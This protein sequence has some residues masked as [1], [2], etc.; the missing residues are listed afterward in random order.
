MAGGKGTRL[1]PLTDPL[2]KHTLP[3]YNEP[4]IYKVVR[5]LVE[6]GVTDI[7]VSLNHIHAE[8]ILE[9]LEDGE[10]FGCALY[11][12]YQRDVVSPGKHLCAAERWVDGDDFILMLG[13]SLYLC[14]LDLRTPKAP[15]I[16]AMPL[17]GADDPRKYGQVKLAD[18]GRV[19]KLVEKPSELF[20]EIIQTAVWKFPPDIFERAKRMRR[21]VAGETHIGMLSTEYVDEGLMTYS[22]IPEG[23]YLDLGTP[24]ALLEGWLRV[25]RSLKQ[26]S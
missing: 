14:P 9:M 7:L 20:S 25:A 6:G 19:L 11:Y 12:S 3:V 24:D 23:S 5:S 10:K 22:M 13:D 16:W 8:L 2:N 21:E 17:N 18:D 15:H 4:M 1:A 26:H